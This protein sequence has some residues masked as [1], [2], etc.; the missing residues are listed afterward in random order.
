M[1][2]GKQWILDETEMHAGSTESITARNVY[3]I[4]YYGEDH[5]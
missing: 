5:T 1:F 2:G 3:R 4:N